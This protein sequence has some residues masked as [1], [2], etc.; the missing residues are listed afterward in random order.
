MCTFVYSVWA[1]YEQVCVAAC[2]CGHLKLA[3]VIFVFGYRQLLC[4][5]LASQKEG[6]LSYILYCLLGLAYWQFLSDSSLK[7]ISS[8]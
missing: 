2:D 7:K 6:C 5:Y 3:K 4:N 8:G 1:I